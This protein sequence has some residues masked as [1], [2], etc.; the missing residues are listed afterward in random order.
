MEDEVSSFWSV[1]N[2]EFSSGDDF[3]IQEDCFCIFVFMGINMNEFFVY[4]SFVVDKFLFSYFEGFKLKELDIEGKYLGKFGVLGMF[5]FLEDGMDV[6]EEDENSDDLDEDLWVFNL[7]SFSFELEDEMEYFV[8]IIFSNEDGRYLWS[9][10]KF[11]VVGVVDLLFEDWKKEK[12][13]VMFFNDVIVYLFD[14]EILIKELGFCG[15]EVCGFDLSGLV[16]VLGFFYLSRCINFESFI[17]EEGG[18]F[19]WDDDFFLDFFM[20][21]IISNLFSFKFFF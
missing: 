7:Y 11:M 20:L 15:G 4:I 5:D 3:E 12:K 8:F 13:V 10:L 14:Q 19:E 2:L 16:L 6:D 21:K 17:D 18:G 9:L 1:L